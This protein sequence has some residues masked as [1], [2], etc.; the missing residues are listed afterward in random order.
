M[1]YRR[2]RFNLDDLLEAGLG[3]ILVILIGATIFFIIAM[4]VSAFTSDD[5]PA[6]PEVTT[7]TQTVNGR[8]I[9]CIVTEDGRAISC[10]W[11]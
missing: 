8:D 7:V 10:N 4:I 2:S 1:A 5:T 6:T 11:G 9:P 3:L